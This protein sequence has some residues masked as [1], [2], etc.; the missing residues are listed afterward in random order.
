MLYKQGISGDPIVHWG[1]WNSSAAKEFILRHRISYPF[2]RCPML[3]TEMP[4]CLLGSNSTPHCNISS[5]IPPQGSHGFPLFRIIE[6]LQSYHCMLSSDGFSTVH[7]CPRCPSQPCAHHSQK[8]GGGEGEILEA[9]PRYSP[10][11]SAY[12]AR[13]HQREKRVAFV[14]IQIGKVVLRRPPSLQ[15]PLS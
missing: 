12:S 14:A 6:L 8:R 7:S 10:L 1:Y 11:G 4:T 2:S 13:R 15:Q 3:S 5:T 9:S